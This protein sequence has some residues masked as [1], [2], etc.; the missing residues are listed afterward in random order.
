[1]SVIAV[2]PITR[3]ARARALMH[4]EYCRSMWCRGDNA[5]TRHP[6]SLYRTV[7]AALDAAP[8][9]AARLSILHDQRCLPCARE[10]RATGRRVKF[11]ETG[12]MD[13]SCNLAAH[14][15]ALAAT[16]YASRM[17]NLWPN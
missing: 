10:F 4:A 5:H 6:A 17:L 8:D 3:K 12:F 13:G 16:R 11:H 15:P 14:G 2:M 1:M 9:R 7:V